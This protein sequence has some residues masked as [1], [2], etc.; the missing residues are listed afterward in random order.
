MIY[1]LLK[2]GKYSV[3]DYELLFR[4]P[5]HEDR[6]KA[7][8]RHSYLDDMRDRFNPTPLP[9]H[10]SAHGD[11]RRTVYLRPRGKHGRPHVGRG[12]ERAA[13]RLF[14]ARAMAQ[15]PVPEPVGDQRGVST[16]SRR[17]TSIW[18]GKR[19]AWVS[20]R[21]TASSAPRRSQ[22]IR[23]HGINS[24][25][26]EFAISQDLNGRGIHA[27]Y[28]RAIYVTG[29]LKI[30]MSVDPRRYQSHRA[31]VD[32]DGNPVLAAEHNYITIR[33]YY[34]GP[35]E[36]VPEHEDE[37]LTPVDLAKAVRKG[38]STR[39]RARTFLEQVVARLH[40]A[41]YD[42]SLLKMNDLLLA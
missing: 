29:S 21:R 31:I 23:L 38:S 18:S 42:G 26:E 3:I 25:F 40:D 15:D 9:S 28:V 12:Q 41:G 17:T 22:K 6:V 2:V 37:L 8:R 32:I 16:R 27:V 30:E 36:W 33:G 34:N 39:H 10:L 24:P 19:P 1:H 35:D 13:V 20:S 7:S 5:E 14:P 4:T 11:L